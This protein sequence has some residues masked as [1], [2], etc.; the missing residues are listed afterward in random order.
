MPLVE[1]ESWETSATAFEV[2]E[3]I[4]FHFVDAVG[5]DEYGFVCRHAFDND[6]DDFAF[7]IDEDDGV[8]G[9]SDVAY[10]ES[11]ERDA[12]VDDEDENSERYFGVFVDDHGDDVAA[13]RG[14]ACAENY[15]Y[16]DAIDESG[17]DGIEEEVGDEEAFDG[18]VAGAYDVGDVA[19]KPLCGVVQSVVDYWCIAPCRFK[20]VGEDRDKDY[21]YDG[22]DAETWSEDDG[23]DDE[24]GDVHADAGD[25]Y[26]PSEK[27]VEDV[28]E[29][30]YATRSEVVG[31]DEHY[32][33][34]GE[35]KA[36]KGD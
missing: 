5:D 23:A 26:F 32:V 4:V 1:S 35:E 12:A 7:D 29:T 8:D 36:A 33:A 11:G 24:Q 13:A 34:Y 16:G 20:N 31:V 9:Q 10:D 18:V 14:G 6:V 2:V 25:R 15:T 19:I 22:F 28:G 27:G 21:G 17:H 30:I 3:D